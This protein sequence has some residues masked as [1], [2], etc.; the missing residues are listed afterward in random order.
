MGVSERGAER[1][2][3]QAV[4]TMLVIVCSGRKGVREVDSV[5]VPSIW[6]QIMS[7]GNCFPHPTEREIQVSIFRV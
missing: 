3:G 2:Q 1:S 6:G 7:V 5:L 4:M